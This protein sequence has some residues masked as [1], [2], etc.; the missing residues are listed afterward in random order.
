MKG[1]AKHIIVGALLN[2]PAYAFLIFLMT[3]A[4]EPLRMSALLWVPI[5]ICIVCFFYTTLLVAFLISF[6]KNPIIKII[7]Y[8]LFVIPFLW[9]FIH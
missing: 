1:V 5:I 4:D 9:P 7:V 8:S 3:H 6:L 2:V